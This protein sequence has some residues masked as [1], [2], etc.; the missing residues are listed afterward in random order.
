MWNSL[1]PPSLLLY[2]YRSVKDTTQILIAVCVVEFSGLHSNFP[3]CKLQFY[4]VN[5]NRFLYFVQIILATTAVKI[6]L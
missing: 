4:T 1:L 6:M 2:C 5:V 3:V